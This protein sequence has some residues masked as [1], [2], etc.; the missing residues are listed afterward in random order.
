MWRELRG[1]RDILYVL[2]RDCTSGVVPRQS[3]ILS[4]DLQL[5]LQKPKG[6]VLPFRVRAPKS[7]MR[8]TLFLFSI[9]TWPH[10]PIQ[11]ELHP[12]PIVDSG[13]P[14][15]ISVR[16]FHHAASCNGDPVR[17]ELG[18]GCKARAAAQL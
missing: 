17:T 15:P 6:A 3:R 18:S 1:Y 2:Q 8:S 9:D 5:L 4:D 7:M 12:E 16:A 11:S 10:S 13:C 14:L